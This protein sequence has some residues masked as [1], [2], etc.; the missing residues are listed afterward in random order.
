MGV[1]A[2]S[3]DV[4]DILNGSM[5]TSQSLPNVIANELKDQADAAVMNVV[6]NN[7]NTINNPVFNINGVN[8]PKEITKAIYDYLTDL[9]TSVGNSIKN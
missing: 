8:D 3:D 5:D 7:G 2:S 6:N 4:K 9:Y 1:K